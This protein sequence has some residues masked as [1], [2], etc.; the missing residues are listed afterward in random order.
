[1]D[2]L[3]PPIVASGLYG[4]FSLLHEKIHAYLSANGSI[5][6]EYRKTITELYDNL[7]LSEDLGVLIDDLRAMNETEFERFVNG[8]LHLHLHELE[9]EF[10][11]YGLHIL[12]SPP[13]DWKLISMA[14]S[15]ISDDL[16]YDVSHVIGYTEY[17]EPAKDLEKE[18]ELENCTE[19]LL[20]AVIFNNTSPEKAQEN[21]LGPGNVSSNVTADLET[22]MGYAEA[23]SNCTIEIP[24]VLDG[25]SGRYVPPKVGNDPIRN[26]DALPTGNNF[27]SFSQRPFIY[28]V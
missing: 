8:P 10:I 27:Y 7:T 20:R 16:L 23:I 25:L 5:K 6:V 22:A 4:N 21:V 9:A 17:P 18:N 13:V 28:W 2:H 19:L 26:P 14:E 15:M 1:V 24:R 12:G 3:I 11:P